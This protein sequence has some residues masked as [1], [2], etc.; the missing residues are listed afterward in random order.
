MGRIGD[1]ESK[2]VASRVPMST[3]IK[4]ISESSKR[5]MTISAFIEEKLTNDIKTLEK[6]G[7]LISDAEEVKN[8]KSKVSELEKEISA[9]KSKKMPLNGNLA[10]FKG[11]IK[12]I[13]MANPNL[14]L[15]KYN[16]NVI[17]PRFKPF[18]MECYK[19]LQLT[20]D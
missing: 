3:Y 11:E 12:S 9:L 6:G 4:L 18:C 10:S 14:T 2:S 7:A 13:L 19:V 15:E 8:L 5:K 20:K 17:E 16:G 1:I